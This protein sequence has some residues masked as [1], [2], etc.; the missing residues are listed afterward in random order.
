VS[1]VKAAAM[2]APASIEQAT[3]LLAQL[4]KVAATIAAH[5]ALRVSSKQEGDRVH[6]EVFQSKKFGLGRGGV[7]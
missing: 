4:A 7:T 1:R 2:R 6:C 5:D 3:D